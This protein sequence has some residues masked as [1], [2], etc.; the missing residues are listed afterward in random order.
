M[1]MGAYGDSHEK[2]TIFGGNTQYIVDNANMP[3]VL[4]H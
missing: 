2:E 3:V 1:V 4:V